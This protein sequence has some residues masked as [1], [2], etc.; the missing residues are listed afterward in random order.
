MSSEQRPAHTMLSKTCLL[1]LAPRCEG[2]HAG[3]ELP[4]HHVHT[5]L[6]KELVLLFKKLTLLNDQGQGS[7]PCP[8]LAT[9][10]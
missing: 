7:L 4:R 5:T 10:V 2:L 6:R 1:L 3:A 8:A 9:A